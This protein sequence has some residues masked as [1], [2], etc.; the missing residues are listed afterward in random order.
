MSRRARAGRSTATTGRKARADRK[1]GR[2]CTRVREFPAHRGDR[3]RRMGHG[4]RQLRGAR[5]TRRDAVGARCR[6]ASRR[7]RHAREPAP[8][9]HPARRE[10]RR[11]RRDR[12]RRAGRRDAARRAGAGFAHRRN[13]AQLRTQAGHA[14]C[15]LRQGHR[16]RHASLHDRDHRRDDSR[17]GPGDPLRPELRHRCRAR[18]ADRRDARLRR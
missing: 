5:R 13:R 7:S 3:R 2:R 10:R 16:A 12:G 15:R 4:A 11:D 14:D 6:A 18:P 8:A 1:R 9:R 17:R